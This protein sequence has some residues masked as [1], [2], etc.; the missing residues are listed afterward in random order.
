MAPVWPCGPCRPC[1]PCGP[2]GPVPPV[3]PGGPYAPVWPGGPCGPAGPAGPGGPC[4]PG[5][6][7]S[8]LFIEVCLTC[9]FTIFSSPIVSALLLAQFVMPSS[10]EHSFCSCAV[11]EYSL[12]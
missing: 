5:E 7:S 4:P 6:P 11:L 8:P 12:P 3:A 2:A 9:G 1:G 10:D